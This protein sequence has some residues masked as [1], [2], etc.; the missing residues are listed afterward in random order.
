MAFY[1]TFLFSDPAE[2]E[3]LVGKIITED[4]LI[5]EWFVVE[6]RYSFK[7]EHKGLRLKELIQSDP[8]LKPFL[9]RLNIFEISENKLKETTAA[10]RLSNTIEK[11]GRKALGK[12]S[13]TIQ[14]ASTERKFFEVEKFSRDFATSAILAKT[15]PTD[16]LFI[17]D[18]DEIV[19]ASSEKVRAELNRAI[20]SGSKFLQ[21]QRR[22]YVYDF[23]NLDPR[24][25]TVPLVSVDLI[26][27]QSNLKISS[28][29]FLNNGVIL[30]TKQPPVIEFSYCFN[31]E[32]IKQK[33]RDFAHLPP[34]QSSI[35]E[36]LRYNHHLR[37]PGDLEENVFWFNADRHAAEYLPHYFKIN[38]EK[39]R[40]NSVNR[41]YVN[42]RGI[43]FPQ[44]F[45]L[46]KETS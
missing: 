46:E 43:G 41:D 4:P 32:D 11:Y 3:L 8:R 20:N 17:T 24:F 35:D 10:E 9:S 31:V 26:S 15:K 21:V 1:C 12:N 18:V 40:T 37:Y 33:L 22:R 13:S 6:G 19:N 39:L 7:G 14:R 42:A 23:D 25:R 29:R 27:K 38:L 5:E 44:Y 45:S 30:V 28:F 34:P 2:F 36:A 16:W